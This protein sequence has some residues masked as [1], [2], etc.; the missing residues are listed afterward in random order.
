MDNSINNFWEIRL[1]DTKAALIK[2]NFDVFI[3]E[4]KT[5]ASRMVFNEVLSSLPIQTISWGGSMT[6]KASGLYDA[7][8]QQNKYVVLDTFEKGIPKEDMLDRRR[9]ALLVDVFITG[10]NAITESGQLVN[11][12]MIGNR[13]GA[14]NFGPKYV[15]MMVGR[16]KIVAD[17]QEAMTRIKN[18]TAPTNS[19]RLDKNT[20]C[21]KTTYCQ[22]CEG[23]D[24]ICNVWSITEKSF[25]KRRIKVILINEDLGL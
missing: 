14:I 17:I 8:I 3:A 16:N 13:T 10:C 4:N 12:D 20:P 18:Y 15:L 7:L 6:F 22:E 19:M 5:E 11:L 21:T 24:R 9:N 1:K 2:N 23:P 25:P